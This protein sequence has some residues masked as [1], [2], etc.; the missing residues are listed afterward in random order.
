MN[1][2]YKLSRL[3]VYSINLDK[4]WPEKSR[5]VILPPGARRSIAGLRFTTHYMY[6]TINVRSF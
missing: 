3:I 1:S 5:T 4:L 2:V 6:F